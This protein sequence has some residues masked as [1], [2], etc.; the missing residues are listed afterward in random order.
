MTEAEIAAMEIVPAYTHNEDT[1]YI[2]VVPPMGVAIPFQVAV[3]AHHTIADIK[4]GQPRRT[5]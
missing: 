4:C 1:A 5:E 3:E 2:L